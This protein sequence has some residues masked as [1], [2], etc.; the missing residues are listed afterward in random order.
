[1]VSTDLAILLKPSGW[2]AIQVRAAL[3]SAKFRC[4][5]GMLCGSAAGAC[6]AEVSIRIMPAPP[7][8]LTARDLST[9]ALL[10]RSHSRTLPLALAGSSA[11]SGPP[12]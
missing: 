8:S 4:T 7:A 12:P 11:A 2:A 9:R 5:D 6:A 3:P 10:P 1:V